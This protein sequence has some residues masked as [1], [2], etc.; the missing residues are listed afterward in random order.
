[1]HALRL[2]KRNFAVRNLSSLLLQT[3]HINTASLLS[4]GLFNFFTLTNKAKLKFVIKLISFQ[5]TIKPTQS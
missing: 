4:T 5:K 1:M 2:F 3:N